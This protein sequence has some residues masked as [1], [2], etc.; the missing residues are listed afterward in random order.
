MTATSYNLI[1]LQTIRETGILETDVRLKEMRQMF[2]I[3]KEKAGLS[4]EP[5]MFRVNKETFK[6]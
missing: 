6:E 1:T 4:D 3:K 2:E 5:D